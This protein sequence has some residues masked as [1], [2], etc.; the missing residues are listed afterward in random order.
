MTWV[1]GEQSPASGT[2][3]AWSTFSNGAGGA[4]LTDGGEWGQLKLDLAGAEGRSAVYDMGEVA[5]RTITLT[6]NQYGT[7]D[8]PLLQYRTSASSFSQ[9]DA[10]PAWTIY[11]APASASF[12]YLQIRTTTNS[13]WTTATYPTGNAVICIRFDDGWDVDYSLA[14]PALTSRGLVGGF[15]VVADDVG[16]A[17]RMTAANLREMQAAGMEIMNHS[18]NHDPDPASHAAFLVE[19]IDSK[20]TL[21]AMGLD[22]A[23]F[24]QPGS[25][26]VNNLYRITDTDFLGTDADTALRAN[27]AM[28]QGYIQYWLAGGYFAMPF[29]SAYRWGA[30]YVSMS[31]ALYTLAQMKAK[32]DDC[33]TNGYGMIT[34]CHTWE[35]DDVGKT[36]AADFLA[37]L[38]YLQTKVGTGDLTVLTP[39]Q[40]AFAT[41]V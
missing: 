18:A 10:T 26:V 8:V 35:L 3:V 12:R 28:Y 29:N 41:A 14:F 31:G 36:T 21:T 37:W 34:L 13:T 24:A 40:F 9:D 11:S 20:A 27:Y 7:G 17:N 39:T 32:V 19:A 4:V 30:P 22:I 16:G 5:T 23:A 1:F 2:A 25:W 6:R 33:I 15:A 38:D